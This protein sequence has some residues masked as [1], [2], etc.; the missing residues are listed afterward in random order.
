[1]TGIVDDIRRDLGSD[2]YRDLLEEFSKKIQQHPQVLAM[3]VFGEIASPGISDLDVVL[4]AARG[5][6]RKTVERCRMW[7]RQRAL[8]SYLFRHSPLVVSEEMLRHLTCLHTLSDLKWLWKR[9]DVITEKVQPTTLEYLHVLYASDWL[10][11]AAAS[12]PLKRG[13]LR[14]LL[15]V[16]K[17]LDVSCENLARLNGTGLGRRRSRPIRDRA[18][19]SSPGAPEMLEEVSREFENTFLLLGREMDDFG[20][21]LAG[22]SGDRRGRPGEGGGWFLHD[23]HLIIAGG[24]HTV[25]GK[26]F[27]MPVLWVQ[28]HAFSRLLEPWSPTPAPASLMEYREACR[29][30]AGLIRAERISWPFT[31]PFGYPFWKRRWRWAFRFASGC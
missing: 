11:R 30:M 29:T 17:G 21:D 10:R 25:F 15:M 31:T 3:G 1:M 18:L 4:I 28:R 16:L 8:A 22:S 19:R 27:G 26:R 5:A 7:I 9:R 6:C 20:S 14:R 2:D 12:Y 13:S 24:E 23:H